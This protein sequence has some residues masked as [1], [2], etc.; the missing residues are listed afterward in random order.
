[1]YK[2][3]Y[4]NLL[5]F[6]LL[7]SFDLAVN[8]RTN[9]AKN[10]LNAYSTTTFWKIKPRELFADLM[11]IGLTLFLSRTLSVYAATVKQE[12]AVGLQILIIMTQFTLPWYLGYLY[13]RYL[14][15]FGRFIRIIVQLASYLV[16]IAFVGSVGIYLSGLPKSGGI[17]PGAE[18]Y[19]LFSFIWIVAIIASPILGLSGKSAGKTCLVTLNEVDEDRSPPEIITFCLYIIIPFFG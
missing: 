11:L 19:I 7:Y 8:A 14:V 6:Q 17:T 13:G 18:N 4:K 10:D 1:M 12:S 3:C 15:F 2:N 9:M 16:F 5:L